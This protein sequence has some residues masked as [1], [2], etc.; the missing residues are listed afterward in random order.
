MAVRT[1]CSNEDRSAIVQRLRSVRLDAKPA[2]GSLDAP[3]MLCHVA[4]QMRVALG[5]VP[6]KPVHNFASRT[7]VKAIVVNTGLQPPRGKIKTS[8]EMLKSEPTSWE[9]DL[10]A[11]VELA[12]RVGRGTATAVHPTFGPLSP[13]EWGRL[14]WKHLDHHLLQFGV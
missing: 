13:P 2:W 12:E 10:A 1:L 8:P 7:L 14:C 6:T 11:C 9:A 5:D 4:D 3:R